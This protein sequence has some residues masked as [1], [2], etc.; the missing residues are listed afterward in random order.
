MREVAD[1]R[2]HGG[3]AHE[4]LVRPLDLRQSREDLQHPSDLRILL[5]ALVGV[6]SRLSRLPEF[7]FSKYHIVALSSRIFLMFISCQI[8]QYCI[9]AI[10]LVLKIPD[11]K[12][13][14]VSQYDCMSDQ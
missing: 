4:V 11:L 14:S 1:E 6:G 10:W 9:L 5:L 13:L 12:S 8:I 7:Q 3:Q 2:L